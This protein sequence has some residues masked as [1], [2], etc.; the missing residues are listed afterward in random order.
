MGYFAG[1]LIC[2]ECLKASEAA[3]A[4]KMSAIEHLICLVREY[5]K[6]SALAA[7]QA[8]WLAAEKRNVLLRQPQVVLKVGLAVQQAKERTTALVQEIMSL[9]K[10]VQ[11]DVRAGKIS[12]AELFEF[13]ATCKEVSEAMASHD[14]ALADIQDAK[15]E[16]KLK[17]ST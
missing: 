16:Q 8:R 15:A 9:G 2:R 11:V 3:S 17:L 7:E 4:N 1:V 6:Y 13:F 14:D 12:L 5:K 10:E